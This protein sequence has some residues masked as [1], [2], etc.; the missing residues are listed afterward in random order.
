MNATKKFLGCI[1]VAALATAGCGVQEENPTDPTPTGFQ[2]PANTVALSFTIDASDR[3]GFYVDEG[4]EWKGA[5]TYD[6]ATRILTYA[7]DWAGGKGP[8]APL[9]DDGPYD[10]GGHEP[11]GAVKGDSKFGITAFLPIPAEALK[12]EYGAQVPS[13]PNCS[14]ADGCWIWKGANGSIQVAAGASTALTAEGLKLDPEGTVDLRLT[15]DTNNLGSG[16]VLDAGETITVKG[17]FADWS[18]EQAFDDG[19]HGDATAG[20]KVFTYTLSA[21]AIRRLKLAPGTVAEFVWNI[22]SAEYKTSGNKCETTGVKA[23]TKGAS[24]ASFVDRTSTIT[25]AG[26][27]NTSLPIP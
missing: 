24:D 18:N 13:G 22:G 5:F 2:Q 3:K 12:I 20:D 15:L 27:G 10:Q 4:L 14:N 8:Y 9:Y 11:K 16:H 7:A 23:Y 21:N 25:I 19:T 17:T 1:A 26:N 6:K